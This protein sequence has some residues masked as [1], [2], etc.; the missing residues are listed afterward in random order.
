MKIKKKKTKMCYSE[1]SYMKVHCS[2]MDGDA[3]F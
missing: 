2:K 1:L 3:S